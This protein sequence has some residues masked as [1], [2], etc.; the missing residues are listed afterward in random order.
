MLINTAVLVVVTDAHATVRVPVVIGCTR[1]FQAD[2]LLFKFIINI[3]FWAIEWQ[4]SAL[5]G[6]WAV[7]DRCW[8][9][10]NETTSVKVLVFVTERICRISVTWLSLLSWG[11][12]STRATSNIHGS[13]LSKIKLSL[14]G[15]NS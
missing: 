13:N 1:L 7:I 4:K 6:S 14:L 5:A 12:L 11:H 10:V 15:F 8:W 9:L 2:A 3:F